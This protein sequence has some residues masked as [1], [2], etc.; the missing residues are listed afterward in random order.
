[1]NF[2]L[3]CIYTT[4]N[5]VHKI[6]PTDMRQEHNITSYG[7]WPAGL[8]TRVSIASS[9]F[10]LKSRTFSRAAS[11][12]LGN[13]SLSFDKSW[14]V[15]YK[16]KCIL[17]SENIQI[18]PPPPPNKGSLGGSN[19][20][21]W[22]EIIMRLWIRTEFSLATPPTFLKKFQTLLLYIC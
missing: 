12:S 5:H 16:C 6:D 19:L 7:Y 10:K 2:T 11:V 4:C 1:M 20:L 21:L 14:M 8:F 18:P 9:T 17:V 13:I 22:G 15:R 3:E